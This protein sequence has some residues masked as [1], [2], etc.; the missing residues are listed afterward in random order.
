[1]IINDN[2]ETKTNTYSDSERV[3]LAKLAHIYRE[4][5]L[6]FVS[7]HCAQ[8]KQTRTQQ[9]NENLKIRRAFHFV[10]TT[11]AAAEVSS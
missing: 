11:T 9:A 3:C 2:R 6:T 7:A 1:M 4:L 8:F 10:S 5:K